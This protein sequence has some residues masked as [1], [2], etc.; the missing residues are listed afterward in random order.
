MD[1]IGKRTQRKGNSKKENV[2][3]V[4]KKTHWGIKWKEKMASWRMETISLKTEQKQV[5]QVKN[6]QENVDKQSVR[7]CKSF[8]THDEFT[9]K[10]SK[11][12]IP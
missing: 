12:R 3:W 2:W 7:S 6:T 5:N 11:I 9:W 8:Q 10:G 4:C 1:E